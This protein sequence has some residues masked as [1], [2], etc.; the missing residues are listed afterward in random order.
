[1]A[2][3]SDLATHLDQLGEIVTAIEDAGGD[4]VVDGTTIETEPVQ[5]NLTVRLN[6]AD[7][8]DES[9]TTE[10]SPDEQLD[11]DD[12]AGETAG[13]AS[14][15]QTDVEGEDDGFERAG[16]WDLDEL[17]ISRDGRTT[18]TV[19]ILE[20]LA[21]RG[22][23]TSRELA[24]RSDVTEEYVSKVVQKLKQEQVAA[25]RQDPR[26]GRRYLYRLVEQ[27]DD[28]S[29]SSHDDS[30][31]T[32]DETEEGSEVADREAD[33]AQEAVDEDEEDSNDTGDQNNA[34]NSTDGEGESVPSYEALTQQRQDIIQI[35]ATHG[36]TR[37]GLIR[38]ALE[39]SSDHHVWKLDDKGVVQRQSVDVKHYDGECN[40]VSLTDKAQEQYT[41]VPD[42]EED[43]P[44][45]AYDPDDVDRQTVKAAL[46]DAEDIRDVADKLDCSTERVL[47]LLGHYDLD[48]A[49]LGSGSLVDLKEV[50]QALDEVPD[51][52]EV[53]G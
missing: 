20:T 39:C 34:N 5:V 41:E 6:A 27:D 40:M 13:N 32:Q 3:P 7:S 36:A 26:D 17:G 12:E 22:E 45:T 28:Q 4:V 9:D 37:Q 24:E 43:L 46:E 25:S 18:A 10:P 33:D 1:V 23:A 50:E 47:R 8:S 38:K 42:W 29:E 52:T 44:E 53:E 21:E 49:I 51:W 15:D 2:V 11:E 14:A 31:D 48:D 30:A 16:A 19:D 35:L